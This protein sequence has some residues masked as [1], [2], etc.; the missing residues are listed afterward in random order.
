MCVVNSRCFARR[1]VVAGP[2]G[3]LAG[4][5]PHFFTTFKCKTNHSRFHHV[6]RA[7]PGLL[8]RRTRQVVLFWRWF[9]EFIFTSRTPPFFTFL[10]SVSIFFFKCVS[11]YGFFS[12]HLSIRPVLYFCL[13]HTVCHPVPPALVF[14]YR[15]FLLSQAVSFSL[16]TFFVPQVF[17]FP[18]NAC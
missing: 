4:A 14:F 12:L 6:L 18:L 1:A 15:L 16:A 9:L 5:R 17:C 8:D 2:S 7:F 13:Y 11:F 3:L 10:W